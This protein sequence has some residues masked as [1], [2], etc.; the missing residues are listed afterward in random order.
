MANQLSAKEYKIRR[1]LKKASKKTVMFGLHLRRRPGQGEAEIARV[2]RET[3]E[4]F[5]HQHNVGERFLDFY[6]PWR[7]IAIE[8]DGKDH[9]LSSAV[10]RDS[11]R[12]HFLQNVGIAEIVRIEASHARVSPQLI[13]ELIEEFKV[14]RGRHIHHGCFWCGRL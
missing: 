6:L 14:V 1:G 4:L 5:C 10:A 11:V 13:L 8:I 12:S 9:R 7:N 2:L 3:G